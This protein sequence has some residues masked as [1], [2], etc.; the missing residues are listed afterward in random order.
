MSSYSVLAEFYDE[1][2]RDVPYERFADYY[3][4]TWDSY[5]VKPVTVLDLACGTGSITKLLAQRG[6]EMISVDSSPEMLSVLTDKCSAVEG[7]VPPLILNQSMTELDLY[8]VVSA[9]VCTLD[10]INYVPEAELDEVFHRLR[11][12]IEPGG[13][14]TFDIN[15]PFKLSQ[16]DGQVYIDETEN[17]Y[18]VWRPELSEEGDSITYGMDIF[19]RDG[20]SWLRTQEEHTEYIHGVS[21]LREKLEQNGFEDIRICGEL[22]FEKP[23]ESEQRIFISARRSGN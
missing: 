15:S 5:G 3:E 22:S 10:G 7:A 2:T 20:E 16:Q 21:M 17:V 12:F 23:A 4:K 11:L 9:A 1:L 6:Y 8:D 13:V 14:L 19:F 18:C